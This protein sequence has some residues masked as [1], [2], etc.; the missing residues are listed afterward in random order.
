MEE[1]GQSEKVIKIVMKIKKT[2]ITGKGRKKSKGK[3]YSVCLF[4]SLCP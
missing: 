4:V 3:A 2:L 1:R